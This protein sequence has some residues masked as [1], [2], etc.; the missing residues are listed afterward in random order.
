[1]MLWFRLAFHH[2]EYFKAVWDYVEHD[3]MQLKCTVLE[4]G[5]LGKHTN[6]NM[7][8]INQVLDTDE[9]NTSIIKWTVEY[10]ESFGDAIQEHFKEEKRILAT[11]LESHITEVTRK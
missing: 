1:M 2:F 4:G 8:Y 9:P 11:Y 6:P 10:D 3:K 7:S 5:Y